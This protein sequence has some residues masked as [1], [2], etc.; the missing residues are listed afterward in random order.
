[1]S[2]YIIVEVTTDDPKA[3]AAYRILTTPIVA[4]FN[5]KFIV[6][7]G[8]TKTLEG[9][10]APERVVVI[11]FPTVEDANKWWNSDMYAEAKAMRQRA[12]RTKMI[13]VQGV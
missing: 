8:E 13:V 4:A 6:R 5:G 3:M 11:E 7:G 1:M 9:D 2:A 12:G 10:W